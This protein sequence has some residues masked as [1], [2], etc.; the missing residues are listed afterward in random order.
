MAGLSRP[1]WLTFIFFGGT[2]RRRREV[3]IETAAKHLVIWLIQI[4]D[5]TMNQSTASGSHGQLDAQNTAS[6][7]PVCSHS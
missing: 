2:R 7:L 1:D 5:E 6:Y 4:A 3:A